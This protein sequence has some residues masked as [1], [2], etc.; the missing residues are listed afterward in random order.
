MPHGAWNVPQDA[1]G[2][3][4][5]ARET[6]VLL[7]LWAAAVL[8]VLGGAFA[9]IHLTR[10]ANGGW[11]WA[12]LVGLA[13]L[14]GKYVI[15]SG[16]S[17]ASPLGPWGLCLLAIG[18]DV[19]VALTL[20]VGLGPL[21]RIPGVGP[22]LRGIHQRAEVVLHDFPRLRRMAFWGVVLF[23]YLPLPAS[24][25]VGGT[26]VGQLLGL[27]RR[28][29]LAAVVLAGALVSVTFAALAVALG[30]QAEAVIRNPWVSGIAAALFVALVLA[31]WRVVK[32]SLRG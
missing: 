30:S 1:A 9:W 18:A 3:A 17:S 25:S 20:A 14:P 22:S 16:V 28:A 21:G 13:T 31:A 5:Q 10:P 11:I 23:V 19:L 2:R 24:G 6:R 26:F 7:A 27:S 29:G 8:V 12:Q 4:A 32:R 15:F